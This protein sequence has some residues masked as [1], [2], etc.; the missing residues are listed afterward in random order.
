[1]EFLQNPIEAGIVE[2]KTISEQDLK[3]YHRWFT[4][5]MEWTKWDAPW[6]EMDEQFVRSY[7]DKLALRLD[8][9]P[10]T[11]ENRLEIYCQN[12]HSGWVNSYFYNKDRNQIAIGI[13]IA[14]NQHWG[15]GIGKNAFQQWAK[16][17]FENRG[18]TELFCETWSGNERMVKLALGIGFRIIEDSETVMV[19]G[20]DYKRLKLKL[21]HKEFN[22]KTNDTLHTR[23]KIITQADVDELQKVKPEQINSKEPKT[24]NMITQEDIEKLLD[25]GKG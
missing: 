14:E 10:Q 15:K 11:I 1:M 4:Q 21:C 2:L 25:K 23:K 17:L 6:E 18:M 12:Q 16:Y 22:M 9:V 20:R 13:V 3:D 24:G 7:L 19:N 5:E 8:K